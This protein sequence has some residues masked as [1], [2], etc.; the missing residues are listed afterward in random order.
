M[1]KKKRIYFGVGMIFF[2]FVLFLVIYFHQKAN[3]IYIIQATVSYVG[4]DYLLVQDNQGKEYSLSLK[5]NY[6]VGDKIIFEVK[7]MKKTNPIEGNV[8]S[9]EKVNQD[10]GFTIH[11]EEN[12]SKD[13]RNVVDENGNESALSLE[14]AS[15]NSGSEEEVVASLEELKSEVDN[16]SHITSSIKHGFIELVDFLLYDGTIRG[17]T[18]S[19]LSNSA[20]IK[21]LKIA[22]L[23]DTKIEEKFPDYKESIKSA[24]SFAY[25]KFREKVI[26]SYFDLAAK[27]CQE[28]EESCTTAKEGISELKKSGSL[29]WQ[30]IKNLTSSSISKLKSWYE[31]WRET[32]D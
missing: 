23:I 2:I 1:N 16:S 6:F 8:L 20:K 22:F 9:V 31:V 32:D 24:S 25:D 14:Q 19:S 13:N 15:D 7:N 4:K 30:F 26:V 5:S 21:V 10:I 12:T 17:K 11:D 18:F 3:Q 28:N 29:T 27:V